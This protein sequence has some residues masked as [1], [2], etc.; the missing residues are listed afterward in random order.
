M[1][2]QSNAFRLLG[3]LTAANFNSTA[4]Q[5]IKIDGAKY[6]IRHV[7]VTNA[8]VSMTLAAGGLYDAAS[9]GGNALVSAAQIYT[10][11][12]ASTKYS[13]MTLAGL[14]GTDVQTAT[15]LYLS[16]TTAQGSAAT[17]DVYI[18]GEAL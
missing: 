9:K 7:I 14:L 11:L 6:I 1:S 8:S 5:A 16:L 18:W 15:T 13:E 3:K 10:G 4:D 12:T 2:Y 17:A